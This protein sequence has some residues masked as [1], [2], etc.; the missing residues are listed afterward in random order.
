M[1]DGAYFLTQ[2]HFL[3]IY[4]KLKERYKEK[5][6]ETYNEKIQLMEERW[7]TDMNL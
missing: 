7:A 5:Y 2:K 1:D 4:M 6:K 3:S